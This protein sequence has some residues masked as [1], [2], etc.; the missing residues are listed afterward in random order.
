MGKFA[1]KIRGLNAGQVA[2]VLHQQ[3]HTQDENKTKNKLRKA[4]KKETKEY[5][6]RNCYTLQL[7]RIDGQSPFQLVIND[8]HCL[9]SEMAQASPPFATILQQSI[10][11]DCLGLALYCDE[12]TPGNPLAPDPSRKI[13]VFY[14]APACGPPCRQESTWSILTAIRQRCACNIEGGM[15]NVLRSVVHSIMQ[16]NQPR[17]LIMGRQRK[18]LTYSIDLV[19]ADEAALHAMLSCKGSAGRKP[20]FRCSTLISKACAAQLGM[21]AMGNRFQGLGCPRLSEIHQSSDEGIWNIL[22]HLAT[23]CPAQTKQQFQELERN[24]GWVHS[25]LSLQLDPH[26]RKELPP[27]SFIFDPLHCYF[28]QGILGYEVKLLLDLLASDGFALDEFANLVRRAAKVFQGLH[29]PNCVALS[30]KYFGDKQWKANASSQN[31]LWPLMHFVLH[32]NMCRFTSPSVIEALK[33]F[34]TLCEEL[35]HIQIMKH[36]RK[37]NIVSTLKD[38]Q[39]KHLQRFA[40]VH[41]EKALRPK[42]HYRLHVV[43]EYAKRGFMYDCVTMERKHRLVKAEIENRSSNLT[44]LDRTIVQRLSIVQLAEMPKYR[45]DF[46]VLSSNVLQHGSMEIKAF[47]PL[48][49]LSTQCILVPDDFFPGTLQVFARGNL[50]RIKNTHTANITE[51]HLSERHRCM[52]IQQPWM[53]PTYWNLNACVLTTLL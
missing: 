33:C 27:S 46:R 1:I 10:C 49:L 29:T 9:M 22:D 31:G 48:L 47:T 51:W 43:E 38:I 35:K 44:A 53:I 19:I 25:P 41:G 42:H 30:A 3:G 37:V 2:R 20:C 26:L 15:A 23:Q 18:V 12:I 17:I 36:T 13:S 14:V 34:H 4:T 16:R 7:P 40:V 8:I 5:A 50:Y 24:V 28:S 11:N 6:K 21:E 52:E 45:Y 39:S 32:T